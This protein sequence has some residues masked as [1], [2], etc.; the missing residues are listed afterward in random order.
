MQTEQLYFVLA[1]LSATFIV[2]LLLRL[3][4]S[5]S[6]TIDDLRRESDRDRLQHARILQQKHAQEEALRRTTRKINGKP[7]KRSWGHRRQRAIRDHQLQGA[8]SE[9]FDAVSSRERERREGTPWGWPSKAGHKPQ[10]RSVR[11]RTT[12]SGISRFWSGLFRK[13]EE[14]HSDSYKLR[15]EQ[16]LRNMVEDR[17]GRASRDVEMTEIDW[18]K[19]NLPSELVQEREVEHMLAWKPEQGPRQMRRETDKL[20]VVDFPNKSSDDLDEASGH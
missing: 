6:R 5:A 7:V 12:R 10:K 13:K 2:L 18:A 15:C 14:V 17:Y 11:K 19:P 8:A 16:S 3:G 1:V 4:K 20:K 9:A